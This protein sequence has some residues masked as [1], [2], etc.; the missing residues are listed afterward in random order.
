MKKF[1]T[2][3]LCSLLVVLSLNTT[4]FAKELKLYNFIDK[5]FYSSEK[6]KNGKLTYFLDFHIGT[7]F[8]PETRKKYK[9]L[10]P[11]NIQ[12]VLTPIYAEKPKTLTLRGE[13]LKAEIKFSSEKI[14]LN[15][16]R[17]RIDLKDQQLELGDY[18]LEADDSGF[19]SPFTIDPPQKEGQIR[20]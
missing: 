6:L 7:S 1:L 3:F 15:E 10:V 16:D 14:H 5:T 20:F 9:E 13:T 11:G 2:V 18:T 19:Y 8:Y 17:M 12:P 4:S